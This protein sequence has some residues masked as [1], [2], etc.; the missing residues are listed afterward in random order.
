MRPGIS[1]DEELAPILADAAAVVSLQRNTFNSGGPFYAL[2]RNLPIIIN[3][4]GQADDLHEHV[5]ADW[6][7]AVPTTVRSLDV[8]DLEEWLGRTRSSPDLSRYEVDVIAQEHI[9]L[10][11]LLRSSVPPLQF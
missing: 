7:Y 10:Y 8:P 4:G 2:P 1:S 5:G 3:Q 9:E 11:E 6:V